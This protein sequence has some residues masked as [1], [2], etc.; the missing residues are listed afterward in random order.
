M[1]EQSVLN[2]RKNKEFFEAM[3]VVPLRADKGVIPDAVEEIL[4][5]L[6]NPRTAIPFYAVYGP[7]SDEPIT[8]DD[9]LITHAM[10]Q[11]AVKKVAGVSSSS[12]EVASSK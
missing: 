12:P 6:G 11:E 2:T 4:T 5:E 8:L 7:G 10:V 3:S 1:N 9:A